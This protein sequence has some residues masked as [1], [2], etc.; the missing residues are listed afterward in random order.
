[1]KGQLD[2]M[3]AEA[4]Q[5]RRDTD[6][7]L[8]AMEQ[9]RQRDAGYRSW[10]QMPTGPLPEATLP[11]NVQDWALRNDVASPQPFVPTLNMAP[12]WRPSE[13]IED[14]RGPTD[15]GPDI[16]PTVWSAPNPEQSYTPWID[17]ALEKATAPRRIK[18]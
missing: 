3:L 1:M 8:E 17:E 18:Q 11:P 16:A 7:M 2:D 4:D 9:A 12:A 15:P 5:Q 6:A 13:N 10:T 14:R